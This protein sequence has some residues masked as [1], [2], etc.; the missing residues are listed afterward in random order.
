[1]TFT[2]WRRGMRRAAGF[3]PVFL[4]G[5]CVSGPQIRD[6]AITEFAR[7]LSDIA[8]QLFGALL[9]GGLGVA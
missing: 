3:A 6:F 5:G 9:T 8:G 4:L 7:V 2:R 1:M